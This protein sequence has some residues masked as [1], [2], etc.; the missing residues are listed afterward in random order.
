MAGIGETKG[1]RVRLLYNSVSCWKTDERA[2]LGGI[3]KQS[4]IL[5]SF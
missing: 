5:S 4:S 1:N 3:L 2:V